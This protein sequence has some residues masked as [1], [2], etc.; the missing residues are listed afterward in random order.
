MIPF[1]PR[2]WDKQYKKI[3]LVNFIDFGTEEIDFVGHLGEPKN[4]AHFEL[5]YPTSLEDKNKKT[6]YA[7]DLVRHRIGE[8]HEWS[9]VHEVIFMHGAF[10]IRGGNPFGARYG[11]AFNWYPMNVE[12]IGNIWEN[13]ELL[14]KV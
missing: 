5:M 10:M 4:W 2:A 7:G 12:V 14:E 6:I 11:E 1:Q 9:G 8:G 3:V 13:P